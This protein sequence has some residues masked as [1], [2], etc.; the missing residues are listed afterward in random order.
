MKSIIKKLLRESL[1]GED[2]VNIDAIHNDVGLFVKETNGVFRLTLY[3]PEYEEVY[4]F[5]NLGK[6]KSGN[7]AVNGVAAKKGYG[8]LIYELAMSYVY[9]NALLPT[10][11]GD[12]RDSAAFVWRKFINRTDVK[13]VHLDSND[14]DYST[15]IEKYYGKDNNEVNFMQTKFYYNGKATAVKK[16][17]N[18][19]NE[20]IK[21][22][23]NLDF[24]TTKGVDFFQN[25]LD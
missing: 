12:I 16:L 24:I 19:G 2:M 11:D 23:V 20:Y 8:P 17:L 10:R 25:K 6:L 4:G 14:I 5:I 7:F 1:L 21:N 13:S 3:D 18:T 9:P 22:S 15:D